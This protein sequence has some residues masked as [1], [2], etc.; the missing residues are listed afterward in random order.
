MDGREAFRDS[1]SVILRMQ[2]DSAI[3]AKEQNSSLTVIKGRPIFPK[4]VGNIGR[5]YLFIQ[6]MENKPSIKNQK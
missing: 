2:V 6:N 3:I 1:D 4:S 5:S